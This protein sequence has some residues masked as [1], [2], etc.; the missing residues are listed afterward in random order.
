[1]VNE[2]GGDGFCNRIVKFDTETGT[3]VAQYAYKMEAFSQGRGISALVALNE[4]E[5]LVL[6]RNNRGIGVGATLASPNKK[7]FSI[8]LTDA[9]DVSETPLDNRN[10]WPPFTL[11]RRSA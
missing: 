3:A 1:M 2:G 5:F 11:Y 10:S 8:D 7:V 6:E 4:N 9:I